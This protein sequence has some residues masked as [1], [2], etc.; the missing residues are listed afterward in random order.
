MAVTTTGQ[1]IVNGALAKSSKNE[2]TNFSPAEQIRR[3]NDRLNGL[4]EFAARVNPGFFAEIDNVAEA[5]GTWPRPEEGLAIARMEQNSDGAEIVVVPLD[6][7]QAE[8][9]KL[10][11][12]EWA[13]VF[14]A[15]TNSAGTPSGSVDFYQAKRPALIT[16]LTPDTLDPQWRE[17]FNELLQ[18]EVA[19]EFANKD[20]RQQEETPALIA[21]R[22]SWLLR[23]VSFLQ[24]STGNLRRRK[25]NR[26]NINVEEL[27]PLL[28]GGSQ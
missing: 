25:G 16:N 7:Q 1:D 12:F 27:I 2:P 9:S 10:S 18:L 13:Q 11:V 24:H 23:F 28:A 26:Q 14:T 20:G 3:V 17:D 19:I 8:P 22:N 4:Y 15:I 21:D 5:A 6:D